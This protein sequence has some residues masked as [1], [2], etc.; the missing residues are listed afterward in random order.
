MTAHRH[1]SDSDDWTHVG[2]N[3]V[4]SSRIALR[5]TSESTGR[6]R[7]RG[8]YVVKDPATSCNGG[9]ITGHRDGS[10]IRMK[11]IFRITRIDLGGDSVSLARVLFF[12]YFVIE[13]RLATVASRA[14]VPKNSLSSCYVLSRHEERS[15]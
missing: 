8:T 5:I 1:R 15:E 12:C 4:Q 7:L 11:R 6:L 13:I 3:R 9:G 2:A 14:A 10:F